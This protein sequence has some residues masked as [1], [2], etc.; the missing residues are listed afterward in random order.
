MGLE[1]SLLL[2]KLDE[3][4]LNPDYFYRNFESNV[5]SKIQENFN[6]SWKL[7]GRSEEQADTFGDM[8]RGAFLAMGLS[9]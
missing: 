5:L 1:K 8:K 3:N 2:L 7:A 6:I 4:T 9:L